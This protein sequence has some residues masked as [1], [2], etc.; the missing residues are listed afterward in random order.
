MF[1]RSFQGIEEKVSLLGFGCMRF[2]KLNESLPDIDEELATKMVD[3]A[4]QN[5]VTYFDTAYPYHNGL[6]EKF[7]G[8]TLKRYPRSSFYLAT[9]LPIWLVKSKEQV[10]E[11]FHQQLQNCQVDYFDFYLIHNMNRDSY[12]TVQ[13][14]DVIATLQELKKQ[15]KI[16]HLGFS[17]HDN[18]EVLESHL[19]QHE[20]DFVQLQL[21]Y[22][23][24]DLQNAKRQYE[25]VRAKNIPV[26]VMEPV[27]GGALATLSEQSNHKLKE[28]HPD[29]SIA[30]WA[31]RYAASKEGVLTVLSGMSN[32]EQVR[33]NIETLSDFKE[34]SLEEEIIIKEALT[35]YLSSGTIPC[36]GCRYCMDCPF[37]V[38]IPRVFSIYNQYMLTSNQWAFQNAYFR[39]LEDSKKADKCTSCKKCLKKCPQFID[40]PTWMK[41]IKK[42]AESLK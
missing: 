5:G 28:Y 18:V 36:T 16:K 10:N 30:S 15:G 21:N 1:Y 3:Y 25:L 20:W 41:E 24:W 12:K 13:E 19:N 38:D 11:L 33:D 29:Q 17:F 4:I 7:I 8:K 34:L 14:Y 26:I 9:K 39:V 23:D 6:S 42:L 22:L 2:P 37:G 27:R 40:I 31:I 35:I 32:F